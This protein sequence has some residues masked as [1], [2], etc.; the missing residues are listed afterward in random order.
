MVAQEGVVRVVETYYGC[1]LA[2]FDSTW[3]DPD[4][5]SISACFFCDDEVGG[6]LYVFRGLGQAGWGW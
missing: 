4:F 1:E 3:V 5:H 6:A 2:R